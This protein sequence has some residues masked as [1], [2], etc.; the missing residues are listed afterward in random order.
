MVVISDLDNSIKL[1]ECSVALG[2]FD[3]VHKGHRSI[4]QRM[5]EEAKLRGLAS[6]VFT[7]SNLPQNVVSGKNSVKY[8]M[9][10]EEKIEAISGLGVDY[11]VCID[12]NE[13]IQT[14]FPYDFACHLLASSL[15][16][17]LAVCG[18][19]YSFGYK[20][21]GT[22]D[23]LAEFGKT[24]GFDTIICEPYK[25]NGKIVSSTSIRG[26]LE[27]GNV[28][29]Y[30]EYTGISYSYSGI[31]VKGL[32]LG[33]SM[34][35]P[36]INLSLDEDRVQPLNGVYLSY[37]YVN[38]Q[39][40]KAITN[41]GNK[42]TVGECPISS[43]SYLLDFSGDLYGKTVRVELADFLRPEI[44]FESIDDLKKQIAEDRKKALHLK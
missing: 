12:F 5:K 20:G 43:E 36:T 40:Y 14:M 26:F 2:N 4:I 34:G 24:A 21:S 6:V 30:K 13:K 1:P 33:S 3:G 19:N 35:F 44:K 15:N 22:P 32:Q 8:I 25:I 7:F 41:I 37:V 28:K 42:P 17:R 11:V 29:A 23:M 31:V 10:A 16:C 27:E 9:T 39:K 38:S 18:F